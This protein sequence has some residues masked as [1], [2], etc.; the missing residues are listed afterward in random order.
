MKKRKLANNAALEITPIILGT[1]GI[2]G[3]PFW[4]ERDMATSFRTI[5]KALDLGIN[6]IDTA[7]AYGFGKAEEVIGKAIIGKRDAVVIA[8]K[9]GLR[10]K[11][12]TLA[13]LYRDLSPESI[14]EE[15]EQSLRR[16]NIDKIDLYQIHWPD[17]NTPLEA[18]MST[19]ARLQ[20]EGKIVEIGV[21]NFD[22][23]LLE[24]AGKYAKIVSLQPKYNMLERDI[25]S[26]LLPW[27]RQREIGVI[28]YSPLASGALSGKYT[29]DSK[30]SDWRGKGDVGV[31]R[32]ENWSA[33]MEKVEK[34]QEVAEDF[35]F[36]L[37]QMAL[38][39]VI[40][41]PGISGAIVGANIPEDIEDTARC[42]EL[43]MP[44]DVMEAI[45]QVIG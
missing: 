41:Q 17:P 34:L 9:C 6:M 28:A 38:R 15:V 5:R 33:A 31:F 3:P 21:S 13:E 35:G 12:E 18:T 2:G 32:E 25:E 37:P 19:M 20:E 11:G 43:R 1:W 45:R 14:R 4:S 26:G 39:W 27:C 36:L 30:F 44:E 22:E 10:W 16:M 8:T 23:A 42:L 29:K 24:E 7:P 40:E